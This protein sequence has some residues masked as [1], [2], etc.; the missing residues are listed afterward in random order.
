MLSYTLLLPGATLDQ[1]AKRGGTEPGHVDAVLGD[2]C[3]G[4]R[5]IDAGGRRQ[6]PML[7]AVGLELG[8]DANPQ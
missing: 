3:G 8:G 1:A 6:Q 2:H 5:P 7:L 4:H